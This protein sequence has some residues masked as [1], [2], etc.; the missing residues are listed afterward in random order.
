MDG[1][2]A[3][4]LNESMRLTILPTEKCNYRCV[5]C[6]EDFQR[7]N[8]SPEVQRRLLRFIDKKMPGLRRL[9]ICWF[10]GEPLLARNVIRDVMEHVALSAAPFDVEILSSAVTNAHLLDP[11]C[12]EEMVRVGVR[13]FQITLDGPKDLH[14]QRRRSARGAGDYQRIRDNMRMM[15][16]TTHAFRIQLRLHVDKVNSARI[17]E[18]IDDIRDIIADDRVAVS[19]DR[20]ANYGKPL[21]DDIKPMTRPDFHDFERRML[22][23][24]PE[25]LG[26]PDAK[27]TEQDS[28]VCYAAKPNNYVIRSDG[29][30]Q[31]C[32]VMLDSDRNWVGEI[33]DNGDLTLNDRHSDWMGGWA[34]ADKARLQCPAKSILS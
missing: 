9:V 20:V 27:A 11:A 19:F 17:K 18:L 15:C 2:A 16:R 8:M 6:Y 21:P 29:R 12:F 22:S 13:S 1:L 28:Y 24:Y 23:A 26:S 5:Y 4:F 10:G 25:L 7:G 30:V 31:K 3:F 33:D 14:N 34:T 32:T